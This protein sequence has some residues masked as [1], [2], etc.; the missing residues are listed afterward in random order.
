MCV[1]R[2]FEKTRKLQKL[3]LEAYIIGKVEIPFSDNLQAYTIYMLLH[4]YRRDIRKLKLNPAYSEEWRRIHKCTLYK[5]RID[6]GKIFIKRSSDRQNAQKAKVD[7]FYF[8]LT[9]LNLPTNRMNICTNTLQ[10]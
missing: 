8:P 1:Y 4:N 2:D 3:W 5:P 10:L 7:S 9:K 6:K